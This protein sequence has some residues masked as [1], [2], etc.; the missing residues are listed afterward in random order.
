MSVDITRHLTAEWT[1]LYKEGNEV[2][3][4]LSLP[5]LYLVLITAPGGGGA[6]GAESCR[7]RRS[8]DNIGSLE[9]AMYFSVFYA[10]IHQD[11][12]NNPIA[13]VAQS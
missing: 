12:S 1:E 5:W 10:K 8:V 6:E 13:E 4:C 9:E 3:I 7:T 2:I 11:F